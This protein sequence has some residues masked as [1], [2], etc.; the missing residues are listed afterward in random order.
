MAKTDILTKM[1][2]LLGI[3]HRPRA[4]DKKGNRYFNHP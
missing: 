4:T 3:P 1:A 2:E